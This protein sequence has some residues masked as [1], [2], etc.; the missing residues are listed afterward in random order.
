MQVSDYMFI[1]NNG[2]G[3]QVLAL[4]ELAQVGG[5]ET[6]SDNT[7]TWAYFS[8]FGK[9]VPMRSSIECGKC[10]CRR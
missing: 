5:T 7:D 9:T 1:N 10:D 8:L 2:T 6:P 4:T 3:N